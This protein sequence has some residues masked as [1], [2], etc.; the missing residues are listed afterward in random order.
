MLN[1]ISQTLIL[2]I[3]YVDSETFDMIELSGIVAKYQD[4][5][6]PGETLFQNYPISVR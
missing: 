5:G 6:R 3:Q 2:H 4:V 1:E